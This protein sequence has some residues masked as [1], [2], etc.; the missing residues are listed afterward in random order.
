M[1]IF[2]RLVCLRVGSFRM[3]LRRLRIEDKIE[4]TFFENISLLNL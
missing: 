4:N 3:G 1:V 2:D